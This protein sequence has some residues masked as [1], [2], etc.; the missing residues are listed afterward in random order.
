MRKHAE[1]LEPFQLCL[2]L[3]L[4][5]LPLGADGMR[6]SSAP[7][8]VSNQ[9][10]GPLVAPSEATAAAQPPALLAEGNAPGA[11]IQDNVRA[12]LAPSPAARRLPPWEAHPVGTTLD[13]EQQQLLRQASTD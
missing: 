13:A 2:C 4:L 11:S 7:D 12:E 8:Q 10:S 9:P 3:A 5:W 6:P 1:S